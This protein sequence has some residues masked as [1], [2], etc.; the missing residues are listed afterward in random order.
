MLSETAA[1]DLT[2]LHGGVLLAVWALLPLLAGV[3]YTELGQRRGEHVASK[4]TK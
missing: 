3:T 2:S 4:G 1:G